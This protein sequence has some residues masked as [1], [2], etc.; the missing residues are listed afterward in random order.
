MRSA[1]LGNHLKLKKI[2]RHLLDKLRKLPEW[3]GH[4]EIFSC[5]QEIENPRQ[6]LPHRTDILRKTVIGCP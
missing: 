4:L 6:H 1:K 3:K 5:S 2:V